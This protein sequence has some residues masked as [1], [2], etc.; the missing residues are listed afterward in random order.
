[1]Y[2]MMAN[3]KLMNA[4]A[5][6][7]GAGIV[8]KASIAFLKRMKGMPIAYQQILNSTTETRTTVMTPAKPR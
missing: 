2:G 1:M 3:T 6:L 7:K 8:V 4:T 5:E